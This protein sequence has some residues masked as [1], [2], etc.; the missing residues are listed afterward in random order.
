[1]LRC[2]IIPTPNLL[3]CSQQVP[4]PLPSKVIR[5]IYSTRGAPDH[6]SKRVQRARYESDAEATKFLR[7]WLG[8]HSVPPKS[9]FLKIACVAVICVFR[10]STD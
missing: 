4:S 5:S 2:E 7:D 6:Q 9:S 3:D 8:E 10:D 1:M